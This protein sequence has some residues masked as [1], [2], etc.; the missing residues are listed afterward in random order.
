MTDSEARAII[1]A[2]LEH[3]QFPAA[4]DS[5]SYTGQVIFLVVTPAKLARAFEYLRACDLEKPK[6]G[7]LPVGEGGRK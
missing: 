6:S 1:A 5:R 7:T 3:Q 2:L 4:I